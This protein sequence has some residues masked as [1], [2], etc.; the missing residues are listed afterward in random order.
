MTPIIGLTTYVTEASYGPFKNR[1]SLTPSSYVDLVTSSG[2]RAVLLPPS[3]E[4]EAGASAG[5]KELIARLDGLVI[6][7]GLDVDPAFYDAQPH[8]ALGRTDLTRDEGEL[9]MVREALALDLP[10]LCICRGHQV[11]NVALGGTLHQHVPDLVGH[12]D[13]QRKTGSFSEREV[14]VKP[15]TK[16]AAIFGDQPSVACSHHQAVDRLGEGLLASAWSREDEGIAPVLE[17][18][19]RPASSF[20]VSVQ[21]HPEHDGDLRPFA[22]LADAARTYASSR[23]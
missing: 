14:S 6:I 13:H 21:W 7:G 8:E 18:M 9:A 2:A 11:L 22:A 1:V 16:T 3:Y 5:V 19:E 20:C 4:H 12:N 23:G 17:A 15:G 10:L